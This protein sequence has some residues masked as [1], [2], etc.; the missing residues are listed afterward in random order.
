MDIRAMCGRKGKQL[1]IILVTKFLGDLLCASKV[2]TF[3]DQQL[4]KSLILHPSFILQP[5]YI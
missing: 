4:L 5:L 3:S 1:Y 2:L